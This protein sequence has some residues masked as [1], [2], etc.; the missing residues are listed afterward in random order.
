MP[1]RKP[2]WEQIR[3]P[4]QP[5][6]QLYLSLAKIVGTILSEVPKAILVQN[7]SS[8]KQKLPASYPHKGLLL[9]N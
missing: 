2:F 4:T 3:P 1:S 8:W 9:D 5:H 6:D 7:G